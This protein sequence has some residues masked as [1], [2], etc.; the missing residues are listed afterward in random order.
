[1]NVYENCPTFI[2]QR[3]TLRLIHKEDAAGLLRVYSD[4][5]A[6]PYF[7]ADN[8]TGDFCINTL[9][10]MQEC[11]NM[12]IWSYDNGW[13]VRWTIL[14]KGTPI[15]TV[16]MFRQDEVNRRGVLRIDVRSDREFEDVHDELLE[17]MLP[18]LFDMFGCDQI[19]TKAK[20]FM[21]QRKSALAVHGFAPSDTVLVG[22]DG[23]K[24]GDYWL[25]RA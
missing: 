2:T 23:T 3:F 20:S 25:R 10:S 4:T 14:E 7:N 16:E 8:C 19:V 22:H 13:F 24:Y 5:Q 6:Q 1:M 12:W 11:V 17:T 18:E 21:V 9:E 15:G